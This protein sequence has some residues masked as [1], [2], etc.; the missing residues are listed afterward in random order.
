MY[1][2]HSI[3]YYKLEKKWR[4]YTYSV[5]A[6]KKVFTTANETI[7]YEMDEEPGRKPFNYDNLRIPSI[8]SYIKKQ[9]SEQN[10][11]LYKYLRALPQTSFTQ[12][13]WEEKLYN[14]TFSGIEIKSPY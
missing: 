14:H 2:A 8:T 10:N 11:P 13:P 6:T 7:V 12:F 9:Y 1:E 4:D 5:F 3:Y